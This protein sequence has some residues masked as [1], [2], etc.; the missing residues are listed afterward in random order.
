[1]TSRFHD[2]SGPGRAAFSPLRPSRRGS[3][4]ARPDG[5]RRRAGPPRPR[6][7]PGRRRQAARQAHGPGRGRHLAGADGV[8]PA[9]APHRGGRGRLLQLFSPLWSVAPDGSLVPE[10]GRG[11]DHGQRRALRGRPPL[12]RQAAR[13][14]EVARRRAVH[15]RGRQMHA[16]PHQQPRLPRRAAGG[17]RARARYRGGEP[18]RDH[19]A[20]GAGLRPLPRDPLLDLHGPQAHPLQ[21]CRPNAAPF[22]NAPWQRALQGSSASRATTSCSPPTPTSTAR[23]RISSA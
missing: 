18:D 1:M 10:L 8:Q 7:G 9:D 6:A 15:G 17:P 13:R 14:R 5:W 2:P 23:G 16:R 3:A 20:H 11:A 19:L 21:G 4:L 22:N 12:A